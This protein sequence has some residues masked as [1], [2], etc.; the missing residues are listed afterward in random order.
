LQCCQSRFAHLGT[1]GAGFRCRRAGLVEGRQ[2]NPISC[3]E[4]RGCSHDVGTITMVH[5]ICAVRVSCGYTSCFNYRVASC[6]QSLHAGVVLLLEA[7]SW[8]AGIHGAAPAHLMGYY[9]LRCRF[10]SLGIRRTDC[11]DAPCPAPMTWNAATASAPRQSVTQRT[12]VSRVR[13][14][15]ASAGVRT[16]YGGM[17]VVR[18]A[19]GV[20]ASRG[21]FIDAQVHTDVSAVSAGEVGREEARASP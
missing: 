12:H 10:P 16:G 21:Q 5:A 3:G 4:R 14:D 17:L 8:S 18:A 15:L 6:L 19:A 9:C 11:Y 2:H 1:R 7:K 20:Q 13:L